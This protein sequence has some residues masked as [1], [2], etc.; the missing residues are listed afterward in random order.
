MFLAQLI[1]C[2]YVWHRF[3]TEVKIRNERDVV[4]RQRA[5]EM[6]QFHNVLESLPA[7]ISIQSRDFKVLYQNPAHSRVVGHHVDEHCYRAYSQ[8]EQVCENCPLAK[9]FADGKIHVLNKTRMLDGA[10]RHFELI[11]APLKKADGTVVAGIEVVTEKTDQVRF[12]EN[13]MSLSRRLEESNR[14]L[15]SSVRLSHMTSGNP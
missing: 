4:L 10:E 14:E 13:I 2:L 3:R 7:R 15:R 12:E 6:T 11:T 9:T 1:C 5:D 8:Q